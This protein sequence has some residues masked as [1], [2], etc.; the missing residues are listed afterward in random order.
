MRQLH[1]GFLCAAFAIAFSLGCAG[2][3]DEAALAP[4]GDETVASAEAAIDP[5]T[6]ISIIAAAGGKLNDW[7]AAEQR[8]DEVNARF[9]QVEGLIHNLQQ[10]V[11]NIVFWANRQFEID[12]MRV[13]NDKRVAARVALSWVR[14]RPGQIGDEERDTFTAAEQLMDWTYNFWAARSPGSPDRFDPRGVTPAFMEA[15]TSW[16]TIRA[17]RGLSPAW[18]QGDIETFANHLFW[19]GDMTKASVRCN[20]RQ[21]DDSEVS[22]EPPFE[23]PKRICVHIITCTDDIEQTSTGMVHDERYGRCTTTWNYDDVSTADNLANQRYEHWSMYS[24]AWAWLDHR[25]R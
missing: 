12:R 24:G 20:N 2:L 17:L 14:S 8:A 22:Q 25:W 10:Q 1:S 21:Y 3:E 23:R 13:V 18:V 6:V 11:T 16:L 5:F 15:V 9:E 4:Q 7:I 19:L